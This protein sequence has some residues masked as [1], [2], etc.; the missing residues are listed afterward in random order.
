MNEDTQDTVRIRELEDALSHLL[1][2]VRAKAMPDLLLAATHHAERVLR[3]HFDGCQCP[4]DADTGRL[5]RNP[6]C[7]IHGYE[8]DT[9]TEQFD[10]SQP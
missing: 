10:G 3:A 6:S 2:A 7:P 8:D 1:N 9:P 5:G 4:Q